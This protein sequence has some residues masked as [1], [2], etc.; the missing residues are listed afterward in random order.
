MTLP[1]LQGKN[2]PGESRIPLAAIE[3]AEDFWGW[4][5]LYVRRESPRG[6]EGRVYFDW[7]SRW[8][9]ANAS[10]PNINNLQEVRMYMYENSS[11]FRFY[12][13][14][15]VNA[16]ADLGD[17]VKITRIGSEHVDFECLLA[18]QGTTEHAAW[19]PFCTNAVRNSTRRFGY[20]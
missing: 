15:L 17:V 16:G 9:I 6:G 7:R 1:T 12:A 8:Q 5:D 20:G 14:P 19:L 4:P 13:R 10:A 18:R 11:D 3:M 2:I